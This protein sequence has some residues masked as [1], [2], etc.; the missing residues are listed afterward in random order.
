MVCG[1]SVIGLTSA[2]LLARDGHRVTVLEIDGQGPCA[3]QQAWEDWDRPGVPQFR[4][5]HNLFPRMQ[6]IVD[7]E[8]PSI[9]GRLLEAGCVWQNEPLLPPP[10]LDQTPRPDD[11]RFRFLTGRRPA[12]EA[13]FAGEALETDGVTVRRGVRVLDYL[14]DGTRVTGVE[15]SEGPIRADLVVDAMG[16][17]SPTVDLLT[18]RGL[19]PEVESQDRGFAYYTRWFRG[20]EPPALIGP[21]ILPVGSISLLTLYGDNDTWS[22]TVF[23]TSDDKPLKAL[24]DVAAWTRVVRACPLQ[25]HWLEGEAITDV[26]PMAGIMDRYRR[27]VVDGRPLV[28]GLLAVGDAWACTNPSAGR[29]LSVG[30]AHAQ[31]LR[32]VVAKHVDDGLEDLAL[33]WDAATEEHVTPFYRNQVLA[34]TERVAEM[35]AYQRGDSPPPRDDPWT[36]LETAAMRDADC[37]RATLDVVYCLTWPEEALVRPGVADKLDTLGTPEPQPLM[38]PDREQLLALIGGAG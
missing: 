20:P 26:A 13:A 8:L 29:G 38:G 4:Q 36:R 28:T 3:P 37:F 6:Q 27:F 19:R 14:F 35:R 1:G 31:Q 33:A 16:R 9:T 2:M 25:A 15:T 21:P 11:E 32:R 22:A 23:I 18:G 24:R 7:D 17:Q 10:F 34:D 12:V 5:P 30:L